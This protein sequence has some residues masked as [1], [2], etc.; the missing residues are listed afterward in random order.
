M[1]CTLTLSEAFEL[2]PLIRLLSDVI[3][4]GSGR[5]PVLVSLWPDMA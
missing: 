3:G 1:S 4:L 2:R 5:A